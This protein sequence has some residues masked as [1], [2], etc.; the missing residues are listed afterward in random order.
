M[1]KSPLFVCMCVWTDDQ[2]SLEKDPKYISI[3]SNYGMVWLGNIIIIVFL[4]FA[5]ELISNMLNK[6]VHRFTQMTHK[7]TH[8]TF[9]SPRSPVRLQIPSSCSSCPVRSP[10]C[11]TVTHLMFFGFQIEALVNTGVCESPRGSER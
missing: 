1:I 9:I 10:G 7:N 6:N 4:L 11:F 8:E 3:H 2:G 5:I